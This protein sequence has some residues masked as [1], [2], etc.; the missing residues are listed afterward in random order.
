MS[1]TSWKKFLPLETICYLIHANH[2]STDT[3][4]TSEFMNLL[5]YITFNSR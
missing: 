3:N 4:S 1:V 5:G 2:N